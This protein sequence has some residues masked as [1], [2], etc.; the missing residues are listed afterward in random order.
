MAF[1]N[2]DDGVG[3]QMQSDEN[4]RSPT[5][6]NEYTSGGNGISG[7]GSV[8]IKPRRRKIL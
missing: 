1:N 5:W 7:G 6:V 4:T 8:E 2:C 3:L